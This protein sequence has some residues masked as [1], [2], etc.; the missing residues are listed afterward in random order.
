M[1][2]FILK[3]TDLTREEK[4]KV[5]LLHWSNMNWIQQQLANEFNQKH[6]QKDLKRISI[7]LILKDFVKIMLLSDNLK[8]VKSAKEAMYLKLELVFLSWFK[9]VYFSTTH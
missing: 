8:E 1:D 6:V 4:K 7:S 5:V 2:L 9:Q 3:K